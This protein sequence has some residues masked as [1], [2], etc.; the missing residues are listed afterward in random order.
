[1]YYNFQINGKDFIE[2]YNLY[3]KLQIYMSY[4]LTFYVLHNLT[5]QHLKCIE[6]TSGKEFF[7]FS[8]QI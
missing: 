2:L 7:E 4:K 3:A 5:I 8:K 6:F 1:M